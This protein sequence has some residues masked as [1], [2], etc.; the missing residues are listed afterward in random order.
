MLYNWPLGLWKPQPTFVFYH[1]YVINA[2]FM[3]VNTGVIVF[4]SC[5]SILLCFHCLPYF[6]IIHTIVYH[7]YI[8]NRP[9]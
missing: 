8:I 2:N 7:I 1:L 3:K 9:W 4:I 6:K 5:D